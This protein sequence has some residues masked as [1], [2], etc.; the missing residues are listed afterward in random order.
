M[1]YKIV[2]V[3]LI[4]AMLT[5][6]CIQ[7][8]KTSYSYY[9]TIN[10]INGRV[11]DGY[12]DDATV[13]IDLNR[14]GKCETNEPSAK[15]D[16]DGKFSLSYSTDINPVDIILIAYGGVDI[17]TNK[18]FVGFLESVGADNGV[19]ITPLTTVVSKLQNKGLSKEEAIQKVANLFGVNADDIFKDPIK[20]A[21]DGNIELLKSNIEFEKVVEALASKQDIKDALN[22]LTDKIKTNSSLKDAI[23]NLGDANLSNKLNE[24]LDDIKSITDD[25]INKYIKKADELKDQIVNKLKNL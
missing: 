12:L 18:S 14:N 5:T 10:T 9:S 20:L 3:S 4:V 2:T 17:S 21:K 13:C 1:N 8:K 19:N 25:N 16:S 24:L 6:G 23:D 7:Q 22:E 11:V 15:T